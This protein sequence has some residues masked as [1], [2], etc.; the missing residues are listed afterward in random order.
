MEQIA[1]TIKKGEIASSCNEGVPSFTC[2]TVMI[3]GDVKTLGISK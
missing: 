2:F 3:A 1:M